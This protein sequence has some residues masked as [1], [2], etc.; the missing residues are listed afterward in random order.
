MQYIL[1]QQEYDELRSIQKRRIALSDKRLQTLCTKIADTMPVKW[2]WETPDVAKP[3]GCIL[4]VDHEWYCDQCPVQ[5]IC[6]NV[7]KAWSK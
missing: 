5:E 7:S 1:S 3:W 6:P 4:S 2:G